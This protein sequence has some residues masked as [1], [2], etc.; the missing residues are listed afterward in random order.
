MLVPDHAHKV[1]NAKYHGYCVDLME[2]IAKEMKF[3]YDIYL[4]PDDEWDGLVLELMNGVSLFL[5]FGWPPPSK[6]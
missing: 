1:G 2:A 6:K 4:P 5:L 3:E